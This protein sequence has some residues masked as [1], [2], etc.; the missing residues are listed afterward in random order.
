MNLCEGLETKPRQ[1]TQPRH[2]HKLMIYVGKFVGMMTNHYR[3]LDVYQM[4]FGAAME[5]LELSQRFPVRGE[6]SIT[7]QIRLSSRLVCV[8]LAKV[9]RKRHDRLG[10]VSQLNACEAEA[11]VARSCIEF[12]ANCG[13]LDVE[14]G[15][16]I[17]AQYHQ[18]LGIL[19]GMIRDP[20]P[21][22]LES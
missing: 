13:Y 19:V 7:T 17:E 15:R 4:A 3:N 9:W 18:I 22:L 1:E 12:A 6:Y 16:E 8:N 21:W 10:F 11:T 2:W 14:V 5:I 20:S